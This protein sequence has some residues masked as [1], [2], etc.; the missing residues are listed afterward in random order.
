MENQHYEGYTISLLDYSSRFNVCGEPKYY[1]YIKLRFTVEREGR[2]QL[3]RFTRISPENKWQR[4]KYS[5][6]TLKL[7][8]F[9]TD[10]YLDLVARECINEVYTM[11]L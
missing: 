5:S 8:K 1:K 11:F 7:K 9:F 6:D 3:F 10:V 4:P 2:V